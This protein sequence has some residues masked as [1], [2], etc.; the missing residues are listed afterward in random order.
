MNKERMAEWT[1]THHVG[2]SSRTMWTALMGIKPTKEMFR[3]DIP[4]DSDDFSRCY[5][6]VKFCEV[7]QSEDFP[8]ILQVFPWYEPIIRNWD[9]LSEMY[10]NNNFRGV[11]D[12][13]W[14]LRKECKLKRNMTTQ[15][16]LKILW[17]DASEEPKDDKRIIIHFGEDDCGIYTWSGMNENKWRHWCKVVHALRWAYVSD[18]LPKGVSDN[19]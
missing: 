13:L 7:S 4:Y 1:V 14:S 16:N 9:K 17:H 19:N 6:L 10:E 18:L 8:K 5:D 15:P 11:N 3:Y 12:L 2:I